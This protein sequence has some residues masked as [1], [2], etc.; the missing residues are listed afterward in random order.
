LERNAS[1]KDQQKQSKRKGFPQQ[2]DDED[3]G[4]WLGW[5]SWQNYRGNPYWAQ[6]SNET[7]DMVDPPHRPHNGDQRT[8]E[9]IL[10]KEKMAQDDFALYSSSVS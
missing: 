4:P 10:L 8:D 2:Q 3:D 6:S 1:R 5:S 7:L 9:R